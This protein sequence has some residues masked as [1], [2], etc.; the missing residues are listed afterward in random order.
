MRAALAG[1]ALL[2]LTGCGSLLGPSG[3]APVYYGLNAPRAASGAAIDQQLLID[4]PRAS[5]D[6]DTTRIA[7]MQKPNA[8][9][10]YADVL[11]RDR[12]PQMIQ[13]LLVRTLDGSR[14]FRAVAAANSGLRADLLLLTD[15]GHF[16]AEAYQNDVHVD[17]TMRLV[18][19]ADRSI[20]A[21]RTFSATAPTA[22]KS[23]D[24]VVAAY[25]R[26]TSDVMVEIAAWAANA[27]L[28]T[29]A[30]E[31]SRIPKANRTR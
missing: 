22:S 25:D 1:L 11:W 13:T 20:V 4:V 28:Q 10:Y 27:A 6:L 26:A 3:P 2:A 17:L 18:H 5:L 12:T 14:R 8:V 31:A 21:T 16:E 24:D 19:A 23:F 29:A 7:V 9:E 15:I 30:T